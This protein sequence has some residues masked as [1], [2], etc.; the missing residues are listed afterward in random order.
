MITRRHLL[1]A[2]A[3][4]PFVSRLP[5]ARGAA[6]FD[7]DFGSAT[8]AARAIR[9]GVISSR[10]LTAHVFARIRQY[11]PRVNAFVTLVEDQAI[12]R[13]RAADDAQAQGKS[14]GPLHGLPILMKDDKQTA[15]IR[16]TCGAKIYANNV[17]KDNAPA[18]QRL[19]DAGAIIVGKTNL[20]EWASDFQSY[21]D[22]AGTTNNPWNPARTSGGSTGG[23]AAAL[24]CGM[25]FLDLGSD[26]GGS[27]RTP[28]HFCGVFGL[29]PTYDVISTEGFVDPP[30]ANPAPDML[31]VNGPLARSPQDLR[32][33]LEITGGPMGAERIAYAWK[34]PPAR[35]ARL[36]D[37]RIGY[38]LDDPF[39]PVAPDVHALLA[40][41]IDALGKAGARLE[42]G[43]PAGIKLAEWYGAYFTLLGT[44]V[45]PNDPTPHRGWGTAIGG[46][47]AARHFWA[48]YFRDHDA[49]LM[50]V[51]FVTAFP[52][53]HSPDL[54]SRKIATPAGPRPYLD[55][56]KW[57]F[58]A[59]LTGNPAA[60]CPVGRTPDG[61]PC[62]IQIL[63]PYLEDATPIDIA[64]RIAEVTGG[65]APPPLAG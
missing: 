17:P 12:A 41:T 29:K 11:N 36:R 58:H 9:T 16:S 45:L 57:I 28:S 55:M 6:S 3:A 10:E 2:L 48:E 64:G 24:A 53:D 26:I 27:I 65:F 15:G 8:D 63:G 52:H 19:L 30:G 31:S 47:L 51:D 23:G 25:G 37:Y 7:P 13:A 21:N 46:Q 39:S 44:A 56:L 61:L 33:A 38:V 20:P 54:L 1:T 5:R 42:Q 60:V 43:W 22:L 40:S 34:L 32:L 18:V 50:P 4:A 59:T 62:G 14:W 49:F 35:G